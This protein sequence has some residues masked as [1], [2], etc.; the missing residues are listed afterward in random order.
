MLSPRTH[1]HDQ[2][3]SGRK[4]NTMAL[5]TLLDLFVNEDTCIW[6]SKQIDF[7]VN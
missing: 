3:K 7:L 6:K 4:S 1:A 2:G 5:E